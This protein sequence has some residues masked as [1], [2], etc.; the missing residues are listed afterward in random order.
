MKHITS[1]IVYALPR[2]SPNIPS[3]KCGG[4]VLHRHSAGCHMGPSSSGCSE[5]GYTGLQGINNVLFFSVLQHI[6]QTYI[7]LLLLLYFH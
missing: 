3:P 1:I 2:S 4:P 7:M 6:S 5:W